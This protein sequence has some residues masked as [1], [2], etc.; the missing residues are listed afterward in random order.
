MAAGKP[1]SF[2]FAGTIFVNNIQALYSVKESAGSFDIRG[3]SKNSV[4]GTGGLWYPANM[5]RIGA[6]G[7]SRAERAVPLSYLADQ[8]GLPKRRSISP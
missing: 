7:P 6:D 3:R 4:V 1:L 5:N 8:Q 2:F